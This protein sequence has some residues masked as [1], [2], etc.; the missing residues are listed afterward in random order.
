VSVGT[1]TVLV[2]V[3]IG[4]LV[5]FRRRGARPVPGPHVLDG[6]VGCGNGG[7]M[8]G[9]VW[10]GDSLSAGV[11]AADAT[12]AF[13]RQTAELV[14]QRVGREVELVCLARPGATSTDVL[15]DQVPVA[16]ELLAPGMTVIVAVG[17]NDVLQG[18]RARRFRDNYRSIVAAL[19]PTGATVVVVGLPD[20]ASMMAVMAQ[21]LRALVGW[22]A[23]RLDR[24][25]CAV[26]AEFRVTHVAIAGPRAAWEWRSR[27]PG[28]LL[29]ADR[30]H[31]NGDGY[32]LWAATVAARLSSL[33]T[34]NRP[35]TA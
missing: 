34:V 24:A 5:W 12:E 32:R 20:M 1:V 17:C 7:G 4:E 23:M 2:A 15:R 21:P 33:E 3:M 31:P 14:A 22:V 28:G 27:Q 16:R 8:Q 25:S 6:V 18:M 35:R 19:R 30:W 13:P 29:S 11:G 10:L 26:A 9:W